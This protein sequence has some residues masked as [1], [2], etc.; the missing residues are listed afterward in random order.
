M[1]IVQVV[2]SE[3]EML[4][5]ISRST[6]KQTFSDFNTEENMREYLEKNLS[7][8]QLRFELE[9][10]STEFYFIYV[11][12]K[13]SGYLKLNISD[14][15]EIERI[16]M[17]SEFQGMGLGKR[18]MHFAFSKAKSLGFNSL[19]LGVW[20]HNLKAISFYTAVGFTAYGEHDFLLGADLQR[21]ILMRCSIVA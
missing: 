13:L 1:R 2:L 21:D 19:W 17:L 14:S 6:F 12:D 16:Y 8:D 9:S 20:E 4:Q 15:F 7:W 11:D 3:I 5:K 18:V 10:P